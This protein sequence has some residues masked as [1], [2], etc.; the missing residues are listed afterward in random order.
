M[1]LSWWR[2]AKGSCALRATK[3]Q[4]GRW[5]AQRWSPPPWPTLGWGARRKQLQLPSLG[6]VPHTA[7]W[8]PPSP[9]CHRLV[10]VLPAS[11]LAQAGKDN[12]LFSPLDHMSPGL[13]MESSHMWACPAAS[14]AQPTLGA[15]LTQLPLPRLASSP[16][17]GGRVGTW[18]L[19][20]S[21]RLQ[22]TALPHHQPF[23]GLSLPGFSLRAHLD[24]G[25][26]RM[27]TQHCPG[28]RPLR[29][30]RQGPFWKSK[31]PVAQ[32]PRN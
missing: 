2:S 21:C 10:A 28:G 32:L 5:Q 24:S 8:V 18:S 23:R 20:D 3:G 11:S 4:T 14:P 25:K 17:L 13:Q 29:W 26:A 15:N 27:C 22:P 30:P 1:A 6:A 19:D 12:T 16:G 9:G 31:M 7:L